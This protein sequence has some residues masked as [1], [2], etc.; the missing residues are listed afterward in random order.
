MLVKELG[1]VKS[2]ICDGASMEQMCVDSDGEWLPGTCGHWICGQEPTCEAIKPGCNCGKASLFIANYGCVKSKSCGP[3]PPLPVTSDPKTCE[4]TGG[5]WDDKACG[6]YKCGQAP[7][8]LDGA[9]GCDCG[10][11]K[12][13]QLDKGCVVYLPCDNK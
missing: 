10:D 4:D 1:C 9:G 2:P 8:C 7:N 5:T 13:Y 11:D 12:I 6:D 3:L